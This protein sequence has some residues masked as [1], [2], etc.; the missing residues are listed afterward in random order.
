MSQLLSR[1]FAM[2]NISDY[3][4]GS[5]LSYRNLQVRSDALMVMAR[6]TARDLLD[7]LET[8]SPGEASEGCNCPTIYSS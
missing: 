7:A 3:E 5:P 8:Y 4:L 2:R 1:L 6:V